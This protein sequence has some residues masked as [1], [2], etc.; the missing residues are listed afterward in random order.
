MRSD[1]RALAFAERTE[2][3]VKQFLFNTQG[4]GVPQLVSIS[5]DWQVAVFQFQ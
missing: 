5:Y 1:E 2:Q 4:V 3:L